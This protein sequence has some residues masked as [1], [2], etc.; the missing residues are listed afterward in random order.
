MFGYPDIK[1]SLDI[2]KCLEYSGVD[3]IE[4]GIPFSDPLADG[5]TIQKAGM[6]ALENGVNI[7]LILRNIPKVNIPLIFMTYMNPV[8]HYGIEKFVKDSKSLGISGI[9]IPDIIPEEADEYKKICV[10][11]K[12]DTIFLV[13]P[14][15]SD[16]RI[17]RI[18][19]MSDKFIYYVS[20]TGVTGAREKLSSSIKRNVM[21]IK[22]YTSK[23]VCVGFGISNKEQ[24]KEI[25]QVADGVI[26]GSAIINIID[27]EKNYFKT[28]ERFIKEIKESIQ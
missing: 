9:I 23:P 26:I 16:K 19:E 6:K 13:A 2:I 21:R 20:L 4:V 11:N 27:S 3:M 5:P 10:K 14:T 22:R 18:C 24:S 28:L 8:Y 15:S 7:P 12:M 17:K 25:S 1:A